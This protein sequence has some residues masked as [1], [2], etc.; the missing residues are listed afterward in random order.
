MSPVPA[1]VHATDVLVADHHRLGAMIAQLRAAGD[2][3]DPALYDEFRAGLLHHIAMEEKVLFPAARGCRDG[4]R[5][6]GEDVIRADH[7]ALAGL[8][9]LPV[10][11]ALVRQLWEILLAHNPLE[12]GHD[13]IY[14]L[15]DGAIG[16]GATEVARR[17]REVPPVKLSPVYDS[18]RVRESV[19]ALL[20]HRVAAHRVLAEVRELG[21]H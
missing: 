16:D 14:T 3:P 20:E 8:R 6:L 9:S 17:L 2:A 4:E 12:E 19:Q 11:G 18:P 15:C 7:A 5:L 13:G 21:R 10:D 1:A